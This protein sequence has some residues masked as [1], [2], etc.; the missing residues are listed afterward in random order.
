MSRC[1]RKSADE[2]LQKMGRLEADMKVM[3]A[4]TDVASAN[5]SPANIALVIDLS[6]LSEAL[7]LNPLKMAL[8]ICLLVSAK[9]NCLHPLGKFECFA[10]VSLNVWVPKAEN[11]DI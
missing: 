4:K 7:S 3:R 8:K 1:C 9:D 10:F 5:K 2:L 6:K 11:T